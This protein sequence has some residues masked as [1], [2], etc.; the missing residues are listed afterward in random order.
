[1]FKTDHI[2]LK[3]EVNLMNRDR[4]SFNQDI[5]KNSINYKSTDVLRARLNDTKIGN[6]ISEL[7]SNSGHFLILKVV[8]DI[9]LDGWWDFLI[10]LT[11]YL[12]IAAMIIQTWY[13]SRQDAHRFWGNI[14]GVGIYTIID[15]P[16]DGLD[17]FKDYVHIVFWCFSLA[18]ATLQGLRFDLALYWQNWII[19]LESLV[20]SMMVVAF[21]VAIALKADN[22]PINLT[23][24]GELLVIK[25]HIFLTASMMLIG[26]LLGLQSLQITKQKKQLQNTAELLGN[27]AEWGM[28][29][30]VVA[31]ALSNPKALAFQK[32]ERTIIFMDIRGFT[33][34]CEETKPD[35]VA[36]VLNKYYR[37]VEPAAS[38]YQPLRITFT[39]DE[40]MAI[41]AT[42][43]QGIAAAKSMRQ[44]AL[45]ILNCY[46]IGAGCGV[47]CGQ[48]IEGLFGSKDVR[49]YTVIG[50]VVNTAKRLE[51]AT[52][53]GEITISDAVYRAICEE[54][55]VQPCPPIVAKGKSEKLISW[56]LI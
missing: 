12:L 19:P 28:G 17:F 49:T 44:A 27:M 32:C 35:I 43:E 1:M 4:E 20:R 55:N 29:I 26:L 33:K 10:D 8:S 30:H 18:I 25:T 47:H 46:G 21:Y 23:S 50:D 14:I 37:S 9:I 40:I 38:E 16:V 24:I 31:T 45:N 42:P 7:L 2:W 53:A 51:S 22:L 56:R 15:M 54:L 41:Y 34:W 5:L 11:E 52:P 3:K 48:V 39:A 6:F 36:V 13:L